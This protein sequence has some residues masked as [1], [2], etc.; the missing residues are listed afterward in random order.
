MGEVSRE[1]KDD[2]KERKEKPIAQQ[3]PLGVSPSRH[4]VTLQQLEDVEGYE[5]LFKIVIIGDSG[6]GKSCL[7][8]R[9]T[10][11]EFMDR[12]VFTIGVD[13]KFAALSLQGRLVKLQLWDTAGQERFRTMTTSFYRGAHGVLFVYDVTDKDTFDNLPRWL[14]EVDKLASR[15]ICKLVVGNKADLASNRTVS[16]DTA[17]AFCKELRLPYMETSAKTAEN[18]EPAFVAMAKQIFKRAVKVAPQLEHEPGSI[19]E[20]T[21]TDASGQT[22]TEGEGADDCK[23]EE[24]G[25]GFDDYVCLDK[26]KIELH[27]ANGR[28]FQGQRIDRKAKCCKS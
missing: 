5:F 16:Q 8:R 10:D 12:S 26:D 1:H 2:S 25:E 11:H 15:N 4:K 27:R 14:A 9:F 24:G 13:F 18:V 23:L 20:P 7:L 21:E 19:A 6:V 28:E 17:F 22:K 3:S